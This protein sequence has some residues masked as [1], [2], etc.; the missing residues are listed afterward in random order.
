VTAVD[1]VTGL[2]SLESELI[3]LDATVATA[4]GGCSAPHRCAQITS[5]GVPTASTAFRFR[6]LDTIETALGMRLG[7]TIAIG[8]TPLWR[9]T[10]NAQPSAWAMGDVSVTTCPLPRVTGAVA[11][12]STTV[13][14]DFDAQI[15]P[16]SVTPGAFTFTGGVMA[17]S[18]VASGS[19]VTVTT[20][21]MVGGT[22]YTVTVASTVTDVIGGGIDAAANSATFT[23]PVPCST[24]HLVLNEI[25]YDQTGT[26][27]AE[28]VEIY[29][30][31]PAAVVMTGMAVLLYN[32]GTAGV[33]ATEYA[34][35]A[36]TGTIPAGG[37][38]VIGPPGFAGATFFWPGATGQLQQGPNDG[39]LLF[40]VATSAVIDVATYGG[41]SVSTVTTAAPATM[42]PIAPEGAATIGNDTVAGSL[43]REPTG[44]DRDS[45]VADW[46]VD[47][48]PSPGAANP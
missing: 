44:C 13:R 9:F 39:V 41:G 10:T 12:D 3:T 17:V 22:M 46:M 20:S 33:T 45:P 21:P 42:I 28:F 27:A 30:P 7:C 29:N 43:G 31:T 32:G 40:N 6:T 36:L 2:D 48:A 24:S 1:V 18:A 34:R 5:T 37:Y 19:S 26:D 35:V 8:P 15:A 38:V 16:A 4:F 47:A 11:T 14:V 25:D 23:A